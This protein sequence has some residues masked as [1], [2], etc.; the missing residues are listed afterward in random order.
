MGRPN[1]EGKAAPQSLRLLRQR[2][3]P[4]EHGGERR[5][6]SKNSNDGALAFTLLTD[7]FFAP[8]RK[9]HDE[10]VTFIY[11]FLIYQTIHF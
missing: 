6:G 8:T 10:N 1:A 3:N 11:T 7:V 9:A 5:I 4:T 2:F